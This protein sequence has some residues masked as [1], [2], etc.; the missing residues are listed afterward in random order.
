MTGARAAFV[1]CGCTST[2]VAL[3]LLGPGTPTAAAGEI[4]AERAHA[5][6]VE[7]RVNAM[8]IRLEAVVQRWDA[9]RSA[10]ERVDGRLRTANREL[11]IAEGNLRGADARLEQ[12]LVQ[13]YV[14]PP[15]DAVDV[16]VGSTSLSNLVDRLELSKSLSVE[17]RAI[18]TAAL[19]FRTQVRLRRAALRRERRNHV[20]LG[21]ALAT[22]RDR[23]TQSIGQQ[24][25]LLRSIH[26]TL[27]TLEERQ[28]AHERA[29]A[30]AARK[31]IERQVA[32]AKERAAAQS[33][34]P[35]AQAALPGP[36]V[37]PQP[38]VSAPDPVT[39]PVAPASTTSPAAPPPAPPPAP[40]S[41]PAPAA[42]A[43]AASV[44]ARYL[45]I[46][47]VWGGAS[48]SGFDCSGLV[49]YV[50]AQLGVQ[51]PHYTVAQWNATTPIPTSDLEP[52][53]LVFFDGLSHV[54]IYIGGGQFI[55]APHTGTVVQI[56]TLAGYWQQHLDGARR[57]P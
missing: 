28:A 19:D 21:D 38:A 57:V 24:R 3:L 13:L 41:P 43:S 53:D 33:I 35:Q 49:M 5:R 30:A 36:P 29:V 17:D 12:L 11:R 47:Y 56:G 55:H 48:P 22:E 18:A 6:L 9:E 2:I 51:L 8:G 39:A 16:V 50:Y 10:L 27:A 32:L 40:V 1:V 15:P 20:R 4:T 23:I 45:G 46:P 37:V 52:G 31:R 54:G 14:S 7:E 44:A 26:E 25:R 42:H 34:A